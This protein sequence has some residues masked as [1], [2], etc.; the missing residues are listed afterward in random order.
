MQVRF[1]RIVAIPP[2]ILS[3]SAFVFCT[4]VLRCKKEPTPADSFRI[5]FFDLFSL[6]YALFRRIL[7]LFKIPLCIL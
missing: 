4:F 7:P 6:R 5:R 3:F 1:T 2:V